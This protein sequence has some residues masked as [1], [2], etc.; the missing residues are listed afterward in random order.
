MVIDGCVLRKYWAARHAPVAP[1]RHDDHVIAILVRVFNGRHRRHIVLLLCTAVG[2]VLVGGVLF[3]ATQHL[4]VTTGWYWAI[5]TATTVGYGD[6]TPHNASGRVVA[7][8]VMLTTIPLLA[9]VFALVTGEAAAAGIRRVL[10][11][12]SRLPEGDYRLVVGMSPA[13]PAIL[14]TL[15]AAGVAVVLAADVDPATVHSKVHVVRGDPTKPGTIRAARPEGARQAFITGTGDGDVLV[16]AVMLRKQAPD[17]PI[18]ALVGSQAVR[19]ALREL[20]VQQTLSPQ[21]LIA[22]TLAKS[23]EA[24]HAG[25]MLA[26]LVESNGHKLTEV[27][28]EPSAVGKL[29]SAIRDERSGLVLGLVHAGRF[30][31]GIEEDPVI[32]AGDSLLIAQAMP[33]KAH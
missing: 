20:G 3:A 12:S 1:L 18:V 23:L 4:P 17:L 19:E 21:E 10:S 30:T 29:L 11:M 16:C 26:Q 31:L 9:S 14:D 8:A 22:S 6:V 28:A 15:I 33:K 27:E 24:P 25:D 5:T 32:A 7:S 2:C 13:V